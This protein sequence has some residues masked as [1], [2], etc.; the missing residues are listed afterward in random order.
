MRLEEA[1]SPLTTTAAGD[2]RLFFKSY[3]IT[4]RSFDRTKTS[5]KQRKKDK[6]KKKKNLFPTLIYAKGI[7]SMIKKELCCTKEKNSFDLTLKFLR[8]KA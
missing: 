8:F 1:G 2:N 4:V 7:W 5:I 6:L 3:K